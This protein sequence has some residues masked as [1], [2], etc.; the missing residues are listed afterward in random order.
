[1]KLNP[2]CV[3]D[4]LIHVEDNAVWPNRLG[5]PSD[6]A[7]IVAKYG[8]EE[9]RYHVKQCADHD[10]LEIENWMMGGSVYIVDLRPKGHEFLMNIHNDT[11]WNG[12]KETAA[13]IGGKSLSAITQIAANIVSA[14]IKAQF[15]LS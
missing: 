5:F 2:D 6:F 12:V 14:L 8:N 1:M 9:A 4:I 15:G 11:V 10:F 7:D 3:R 13:K